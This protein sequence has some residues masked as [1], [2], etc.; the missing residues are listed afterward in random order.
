L[1]PM[2]TY[3]GY[4][5]L[6]LTNSGKTMLVLY[7][8]GRQIGTTRSKAGVYRDVVGDDLEKTQNE[9]GKKEE[10]IRKKLGGKNVFKNSKST[11][12]QEDEKAM[13]TTSNII[14][15]FVKDFEERLLGNAIIMIKEKDTERNVRTM[16]TNTLGY[17][18][19][20]TPLKNG[21]YT[22]NIYKDKL[23]FDPIEIKLSGEVLKP[24][25]IIAK[26]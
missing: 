6:D 26:G 21:E 13:V 12:L 24:L 16:L 11:K 14:S 15:G 10:K 17:F 20:T 7:L 19:H 23:R 4:N 8:S 5:E 25:V 9:I 2:S 1:K 22:V 18:S 3:S